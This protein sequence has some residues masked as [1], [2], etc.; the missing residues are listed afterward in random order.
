RV[1]SP[2]ADLGNVG[3]SIWPAVAPLVLNHIKAS[4]TTLVFVNN[5]AQ[6]EKIAARVNKLAE[7]EIALPYHGSLARERRV[8]LEERLK[9]RWLP[10]LITARSLGVGIDMGSVDLVIQLQSPKRVASA[11]QRIGRAGHTIG[12]PSK[13]ILV[14]TFRDDAVE[15]AAIVA[16][17]RAGDVEP[18]RVVQ[19]AL[20]VLAQV[21][22]AAVSVDDWISED[23]FGVVRRA[24]PYHQLTRSA[25][26]EVLAMLSGK[27]PS[28]IAAELEPRI[29]WDRVNDKLIG[30]R[31]ARMTAVIA[32]GTIPDRGLYTVNLPDRT[33]LGELDEEFV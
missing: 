22:V 21:I 6:A 30:S 16:A 20:D 18:T 14:P 2:V 24:Y 4:R 15:I 32:G 28:D 1:E 31:A 3:G 9:E 13:G 10:A 26:D 23:L 8:G 19:N 5:R 27:Y 11:L 29:T 33:R 25:F 17:M 12:V 7:E